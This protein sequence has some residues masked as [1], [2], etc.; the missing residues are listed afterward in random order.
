MPGYGSHVPLWIL[1]SSLFGAELA[2]A[3]GLPFAFASHFAP[4]ELLPALQ[5]Y[6]AKFKASKQLQRPYAMVGINVVAAETDDEARRL[7][8]SI[9]QTFTNMGRGT[10]GQLPVPIDDIETYWSPIEKIEVSRKLRRSFVGSAETVQRG[11]EGLLAETGA[12]ELIVA[13]AIYEHTAR[14]RSYEILADIRKE[15]ASNA[16]FPERQTLI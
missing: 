5:I 1:G 9:Q 8:T 13:S 3:L 16:R 6:R 2:A 15:S 4:D 12:D 10:R 7:F 11:I 14:L